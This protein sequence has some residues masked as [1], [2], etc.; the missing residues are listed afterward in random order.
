MSVCRIMSVC[1][2]VRARMHACTYA[3]MLACMQAG[4]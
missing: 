3:C 4:A 2:Y 1:R